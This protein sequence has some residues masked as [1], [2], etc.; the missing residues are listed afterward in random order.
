M[1]YTNKS[2]HICI[3]YNSGKSALPDISTHD[4]QGH[5]PPK[6]EYIYIRQNTSA[7]VITNMLHFQHFKICPSLKPTAQLAYIVTDADCNYVPY[8]S[9]FDYEIIYLAIHMAFALRFLWQRILSNEEPM[10]SNCACYI[11]KYYNS[12]ISD[13]ICD[14]LSENPPNQ[15]FE[16]Y[17][18]KN[19][20]GKT[21][22]ALV[23]DSFIEHNNT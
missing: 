15:Y 8:T 22:L 19:S 1:I 21:S 2:S 20:I 3:S 10:V 14:C 6:G 12:D 5:A 17:H 23:L 7:C 4:N 18:F 16:K 9:I 11:H 13:I